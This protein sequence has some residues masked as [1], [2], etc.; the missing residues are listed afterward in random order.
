MRIKDI[1]KTLS[2]EVNLLKFLPKKE[3]SVD[4]FYEGKKL[5]L[6][7]SKIKENKTIQI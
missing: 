2:K 7:I 4:S 5:L 1:H 6:D 3:I